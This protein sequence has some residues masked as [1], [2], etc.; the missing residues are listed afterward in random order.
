VTQDRRARELRAPKSLVGAAKAP[1]LPVV[2]KIERGTLFGDVATA[3]RDM[4]VQDELPPGTPI[5]EA[6]LSE[7]LGVSRTPLREAIR[8]LVSEGLITMVPR[9]GAVVATP[10]LEEIQGMF[11]A[12]G[13]IE[14]VSAPIACA[15]FTDADIAMIQREHAAMLVFHASA[16]LKGYYRSNQAIHQAVVQGTGNAYLIDL[17]RSISIHIVRDRYFV[18]LPKEAWQRALDEH[19]Q[20]L[21]AITSRDGKRLAKLILVHMLGS[22]KDFESNYLANAAALR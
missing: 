20:L 6:S 12:L 10:S 3:L 4:I 15:R 16:K 21:R 17:H 19:E 14:S 7:Q 5:S 22:W 18:D 2:K 9:R 8:V 11:Y 13:G 1:R